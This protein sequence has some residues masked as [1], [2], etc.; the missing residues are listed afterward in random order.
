M[1]GRPKALPTWARSCHLEIQTFGE[2][3]LSFPVRVAQLEKTPNDINIEF[4][5]LPGPVDGPGSTIHFHF[6]ESGGELYL[7][8]REFSTQ[9]TMFG[10][11]TRI[12]QLS[13]KRVHRSGV[14]NLAA[15]IVTT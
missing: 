6:Y 14:H 9:G 7:G 8:I 3:L 11:Y 10:G 2:K 12:E 13:T 15:L 1:G 4:L 5:T